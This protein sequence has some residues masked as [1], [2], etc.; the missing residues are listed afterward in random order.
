MNAESWS[1][2]IELAAFAVTAALLWLPP[3][4]GR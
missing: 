4:V 2:V 3:W 1:V